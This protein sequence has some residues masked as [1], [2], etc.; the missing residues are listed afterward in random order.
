MEAFRALQVSNHPQQIARLR[1]SLRSE[2]KTD[3]RADVI[4][5]YCLPGVE[6]AGQETLDP[7]A[8]IP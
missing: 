2:L 4:A 7:L 5:E 6:V 1:V 3:S 8:A